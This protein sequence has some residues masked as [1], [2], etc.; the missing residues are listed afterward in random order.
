MTT[1]FYIPTIIT[2]HTIPNDITGIPSI[3][4][5]YYTPITPSNPAVSKQPLYTISGLWM[6]KFLSITSQL[7]CTGLN[8][9][10]T[11]RPIAG[12]EFQLNIQRNARVEDLLI[13]LIYDGSL[14]GKNYASD[15][16]PV[17][18]DMYTGDITIPLN[19]IGDYNIYGNNTD[20][21]GVDFSTIDV[22]SATF[23]IAIGFK[24]NIIYPH[25]D[26]AILY[27]LGLRLT[28]A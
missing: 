24:S 5:N 6:E 3:D 12:V 17:Q 16:N 19:P 27:Q 13:Q 18:S 9:P 23:G 2:Q 25:K 4:W 26:L 20:L 15:V 22:T 7:W 1:D 14:I 28:Y 11:N 21:W 8:I 10:N